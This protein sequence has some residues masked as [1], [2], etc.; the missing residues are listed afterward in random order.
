[1]VKETFGKKK[2]L[3]QQIGLKFKE[4]TSQMLHVEY[5]FV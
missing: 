5:S 3:H 4:E 1:M 2:T